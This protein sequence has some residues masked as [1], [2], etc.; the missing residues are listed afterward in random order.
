MSEL[1]HSSL[2]VL[3][4]VLWHEA[5]L[6]AGD[7]VSHAVGDAIPA[8]LEVAR[9]CRRPLPPR[10]VRALGMLFARP[11]ARR[12]ARLG[13]LSPHNFWGPNLCHIRKNVAYLATDLYYKNYQPPKLDPLL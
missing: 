1:T 4:V 6:G 9:P 8:R 11:L 3:T 2:S 12:P 13:V 5:A 10:P 7:V